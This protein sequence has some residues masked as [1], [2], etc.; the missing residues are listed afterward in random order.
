MS[1][2]VK[3]VTIEEEKSEEAIAPENAKKEAEKAEKEAILEEMRKKLNL[4]KGKL[5]VLIEKHEELEKTRNAAVEKAVADAKTWIEKTYDQKIVELD[6]M[7]KKEKKE[8]DKEREKIIKEK[9]EEATKDKK[10][11]I[12]Y[13]KRNINA[14]IKERNLSPFLNTGLYFTIVAPK[15]IGD[16]LKATL[17]ILGTIIIIPGIIVFFKLQNSTFWI[18]AMVFILNFFFWSVIYYFFIKLTETSEKNVREIR[19]MRNDVR[20][21]EKT[22]ARLTKEIKN[23]KI[24]DNK[25]YTKIDRNIETINLNIKDLQEKKQIE[26]EKFDNEKANEIRNKISKEAE[27]EFKANEKEQKKIREEYEKLER[28]YT[29]Q[30]V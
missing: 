29:L 15:T 30:K 9:I 18:K 22:V 5:D 19:E 4:L 8:K 20:E 12:Y 21:D 1:E 7:L 2:E 13:T 17:I 24:E 11:R 27:K 26:I 6:S 28:E 25:T 14:I 10:E 23:E 3:N 16:Y